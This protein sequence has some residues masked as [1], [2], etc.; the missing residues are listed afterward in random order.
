M[1]YFKIG[2][3]F[4]ECED[5]DKAQHDS[6]VVGKCSTLKTVP[7][8]KCSTPKWMHRYKDHLYEHRNVTFL[9]SSKKDTDALDNAVEIDTWKCDPEVLLTIFT[10]G[11]ILP[12]KFDQKVLRIV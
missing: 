4:D 10:G 6:K 7:I 3:E 12:K 11:L 5:G 9:H 2:V 8:Y 1:T